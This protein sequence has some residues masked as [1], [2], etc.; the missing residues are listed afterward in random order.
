M[1]R[2]TPRASIRAPTTMQIGPKIREF[3]VN[4][5][6]AAYESLSSSSPGPRYD[7]AE[8]ENQ[9]TREHRFSNSIRS[10][11][12]ETSLSQTKGKFRSQYWLTWL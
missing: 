2:R 6:L 4:A 12:E 9:R 10:N 3:P 8:T 11:E 5:I 1:Q 7:A